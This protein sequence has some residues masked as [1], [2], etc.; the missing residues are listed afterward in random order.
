MRILQ[1]A[2]HN[3]GRIA[4]GN[5]QLKAAFT[6]SCHSYLSILLDE[7]PALARVDLGTT[8]GA[9]FDPEMGNCGGIW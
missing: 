7:S 2:F 4:H 5:I 8:V 1:A 6:F 3:K 9:Q